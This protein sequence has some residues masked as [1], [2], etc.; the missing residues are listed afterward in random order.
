[1]PDS[2][3]VRKFERTFLHGMP[4]GYRSPYADPPLDDA[5][6]ILIGTFHYDFEN[7]IETYVPAP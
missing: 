1:M 6:C 7:K 2:E 3:K 5:D 4:F